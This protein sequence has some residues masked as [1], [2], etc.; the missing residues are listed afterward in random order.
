MSLKAQKN[1]SAHG[2]VAEHA[3]PG[4]PSLHGSSKHPIDDVTVNA[5]SNA[6]VFVVM[7]SPPTSPCHVETPGLKRQTAGSPLPLRFI[8]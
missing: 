6:A 5:I 1:P 3:A 2:E 8:C 4:A 7:A